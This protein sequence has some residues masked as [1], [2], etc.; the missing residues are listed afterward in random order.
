MSDVVDTTGRDR[1]A[2]RQAALLR[3]SADIAAAQDEDRICHAVVHGL[4]DEHIGYSFVGLFL[5]D[6]PTGD[7]VMRAAVGWSGIPAVCPRA[8]DR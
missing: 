3:L 6:P 4:R 1:A 2:R 8:R 5:I 7:R